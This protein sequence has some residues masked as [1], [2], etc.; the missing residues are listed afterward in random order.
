MK[1]KL[2]KTVLVAMIAT[3]MLLVACTPN[4]QNDSNSGGADSG[5][6]VTI[7]FWGGWTGPD[8]DVMREI[9]QMYM[10][11]FPHVN[12]EFEA[13]Q[14]TPLFTQFLAEASAGNAPDIL[15]MRPMDAGQFLYMGLLSTSFAETIGIDATNYSV[16][17][18]DS[19]FYNGDQYAIPIDQ[20]MHAIYYN[21]DMF[22]AAGIESFP[23]TGE[24][25]VEVAR[26][27]T[28]DS[29]GRNAT[30]DDF[31][32]SSIVQFGYNFNMNHHVGFQM[33]ALINQQGG[34]PFTADMTEVP[35]DT[36]QAINALTWIQNLVTEYHVA[37]V[38]DVS[39][40]DG[41]VAGNIAMVLDGP[42]Q[43]PTIVETDLNW[44]TAPFPNV[45][46]SPSAWGNSHIFT[47]PLNNSNDRQQE[48]V[49]DFIR[50]FDANSGLWANAGQLPASNSG[51]AYAETLPGR[52][53][54]IDSMGT[55]YILPAS[56]R[57]AELFGSSATSP[58]PLA[59]DALLIEEQDPASVVEQLRQYMNEI[60]AMP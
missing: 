16:S 1:K 8:G 52:Q 56:P 26:L 39:P 31:D 10:D 11:E 24:E 15:A 46:G 33:A 37:P 47:F 17:A 42:W 43:L 38:G 12:I 32:Q 27:L 57:S 20:H 18:W 13:Q 22:E 48:A 51:I 21:R 7:T 35:F 19:T 34:I 36:E 50:W 28:L 30:E 49:R 6:E 54:F 40:I 45:F 58:F 41:F 29:N 53:A 9:V 3:S 25:F 2:L 4:N 60:L 44:G 55:M 23:V 14:W 5:E 59:A